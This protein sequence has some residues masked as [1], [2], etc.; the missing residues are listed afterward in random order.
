MHRIFLAIAL[1]VAFLIPALAS[2]DNTPADRN[3]GLSW[4][5]EMYLDL[6]SDLDDLGHP[7]GKNAAREGV[8]R[9]QVC[10]QVEK[11][12]A[13]RADYAAEAAEEAAAVAVTSTGYDTSG[14]PTSVIECESGGDYTAVD[15]SGTYRGAYQFDQPTWDAYAPPGYAGTDPAAAPPEVQDA[16][17]AAVD[18]D[19]WPNC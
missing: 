13:V 19:A 2:A 14:A 16:A 6:Y 15:P 12:D 5:D 9:E 3:D 1:C 18:Y 17:A 7:L 8:D 11:M 4:C 10:R